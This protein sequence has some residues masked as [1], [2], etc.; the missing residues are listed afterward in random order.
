MQLTEH[1]TDVQT[2]VRWSPDNKAI[3]YVWDNSIV[4]CEVTLLPF[5]KK[6]KRLTAKT[7]NTP[8]NLGWSADGKIIA[9]N[10]SGKADGKNNPNNQIFIIRM[11][12]PTA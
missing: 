1:S 5:E 7:Q 11:D 2:G 4:L 6:V 12:L 3:I 9:F 8:L 10:R